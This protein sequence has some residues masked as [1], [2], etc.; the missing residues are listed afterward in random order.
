M[1][2]HTH[3]ILNEISA[4]N[5]QKEIHTLGLSEITAK[6][7]QSTVNTTNSGPYNI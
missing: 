1:K 7:N 6:V 5:F 4:S 3:F 2:T